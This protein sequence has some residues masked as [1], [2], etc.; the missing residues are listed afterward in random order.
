MEIERHFV[1]VDER[2][3]EED[4]DVI[5]EERYLDLELCRGKLQE[6]IKEDRT[7]AWIKRTFRRFLNEFKV[8]NEFL[9]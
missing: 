2:F 6:W 4:T 8:N 1:D 3:E 5:E 7:K 9:Y